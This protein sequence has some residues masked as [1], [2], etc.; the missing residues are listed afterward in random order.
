MVL[1]VNQKAAKRTRGE[2]YF[3]VNGR[4][5]KNNYL[6]HAI[7]KG[8]SDLIGDKYFPSYFINFK[9]KSDLIDI[10]I[11]PTKTEIKFENEKEIY[12]ILRATTRKSLGEYNI[13]PSI[14]FAQEIAF[15]DSYSSSKNNYI[16][17]T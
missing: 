8:Y 13:A 17:R 10:N 9:I 11:H 14:D 12:A 15:Q 4:F 2:Q 3:F 1:L 5:I 7:Q 6:N 16:S